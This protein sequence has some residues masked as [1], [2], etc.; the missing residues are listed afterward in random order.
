MDK[1]SCIFL[2]RI[3]LPL[4]IIFLFIFIF[5]LPNILLSKPAA[6]KGFIDL[7]HIDFS[8]EKPVELSGEWEFFPETF[9]KTEDDYKQAASPLIFNIPGPWNGYKADDTV[10]TGKLYGSYVLKIRLPEEHPPLALYFGEVKSSYEIIASW[11]NLGGAGKTGTSEKESEPEWSK[12]IFPLNVSG[13]ELILVQNISNF[14]YTKGGNQTSPL[15]GSAESINSRRE[16]GRF[17]EIFLFGSIFIMAI[18][19]IILFSSR[20]DYSILY[21]AFL[22]FLISIYLI[23]TGEMLILSIFPNMAW[24]L[25]V[26]TIY[27]TLYLS[28]IFFLRYMEKFFPDES[29]RI[30]RKIIEIILLILCLI[31]V[32]SPPILFALTLDVFHFLMVIISIASFRTVRL[33]L[34]NRREGAV[35][36]FAGIAVLSLAMIND[37]FYYQDLIHTGDT[38]PAGVLILILINGFALSKKSPAKEPARE[39]SKEDSLSP[40]KIRQIESAVDF[41][42]ENF[43]V[44]VSREGLAAKYNM[45]PDNFGRLFKQHTGKRI[46]EMT[47]YFRIESARKELEDG[48]STV[49]E[50]AMKSGFEN[51]RTF[52]RVFREFTG[53]SPIEY[54]K[55]KKMD[56]F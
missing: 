29:S 56:N 17:Y 25:L 46:G 21:F 27:L 28:P 37:V 39:S 33:A 11:K 2:N 53:I 54:R 13:N 26:K 24:P 34:K 5:L 47:N 44:P 35:A 15:L 12:K 9:I 23:S 52:N 41:I 31:V 36:L 19:Q 32:L 1:Y 30:F 16:A 40:E 7:S 22:C 3:Y 20:R 4:L 49:I 18:Y 50:I 8:S 45:H 10:L 48:D 51:L 6:V 42:R 55:N 14:H 43:H 38:A